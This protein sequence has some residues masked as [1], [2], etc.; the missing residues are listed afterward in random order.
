ME[1]L[2]ADKLAKSTI[3]FIQQYFN[4]KYRDNAE[5]VGHQHPEVLT[6]MVFAMDLR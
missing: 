1:H 2:A 4:V 6:S 5:G 3:T